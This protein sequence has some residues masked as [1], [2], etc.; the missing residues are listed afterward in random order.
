MKRFQLIIE[1]FFVWYC[2]GPV[3]DWYCY[4]YKNVQVWVWLCFHLV[5][6]W[7]YLVKCQTSLLGE[8]AEFLCTVGI[9]SSQCFTAKVSYQSKQQ[10]QQ[11]IMFRKGEKVV[12]C[13]AFQWETSKYFLL[14]L[15]NRRPVY[16]TLFFG[17]R[18]CVLWPFENFT[19]RG[20]TLASFLREISFSFCKGRREL[21]SGSWC[22][23]YTD[24][25]PENANMRMAHVMPGLLRKFSLN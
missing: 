7:S 4:F 14:V 24:G 22:D 16:L 1:A 19:H 2:I 11:L 12:L 9:T 5:N 13:S 3:L 6:S 10:Q 15:I 25:L 21:G 18:K 8:V 23:T 20:Q 17:P